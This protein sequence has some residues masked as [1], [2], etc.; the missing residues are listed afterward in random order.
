MGCGVAA[1]RARAFR[2]VV[3]VEIAAS[4]SYVDEIGLEVGSCPIFSIND[5]VC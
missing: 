4:I 1:C 5:V 2:R 3:S